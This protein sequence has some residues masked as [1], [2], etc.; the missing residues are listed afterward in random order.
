MRAVI[1]VIGKDMVG[2]L[3]RVSAI[4]AKNQVNVIEVTQSV[5]QDLFAMIMLVDISKCTVP[6]SQLSDELTSVGNEMNLKVHVMHEDIFN[7]MHRI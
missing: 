4:C 5:L 2:I 3:A 7:S 1:T 6:F